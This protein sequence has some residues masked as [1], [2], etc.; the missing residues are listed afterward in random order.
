MKV[1]SERQRQLL[2]A[3]L[4]DVTFKGELLEELFALK[5]AIVTAEIEPPAAPPAAPAAGGSETAAAAL[6]ARRRKA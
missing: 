1:N 2:L 3:I 6:P 5:H 4:K